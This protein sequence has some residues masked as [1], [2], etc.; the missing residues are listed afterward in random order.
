DGKTWSKPMM[1]AAPG[2][3][4]TNLATLDV[5]K[6]GNVAIAYYGTTVEQNAGEKV[7]WNGYLA[8]GLGVLSSKPV[9]YTATINNP[10]EPFKVKSCGPGRCGRVLDFIDVEIA[11]D[12]SPWGAYV[13]ACA[14]ECEKTGN[15]SIHDNEGVVGTLVEGP[16]LL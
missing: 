14:A 9:F 15:E 16:K 5:G 3:K 4:A 11:P 2:I 1:V 7:T 6:P 13:D 12:G 8:E 10:A